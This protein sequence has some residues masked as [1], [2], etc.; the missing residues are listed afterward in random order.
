MRPITA[1]TLADPVSTAPSGYRT[2]AYTP[3]RERELYTRAKE[4]WNVLARARAGIYIHVLASIY[5]ARSR[6]PK[7]ER[8]R[9]SHVRYTR[10][11]G[12]R[13]RGFTRCDQLFEFTGRMRDVGRRC[14]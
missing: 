1:T 7:R 2:D 12:G 5:R 3:A 11:P 14:R 8:E 13:E 10:I 6:F 4:R 9:A